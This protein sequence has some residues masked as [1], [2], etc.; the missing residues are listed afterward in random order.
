M[1]VGFAL[2]FVLLSF[3]ATSFSHGEIYFPNLLSAA[4]LAT[5]GIVLLNP[6][7]TIANV[8]F[9]LISPHG[10]PVSLARAQIPPGGQLAKVASE[11][12]SD[13][14]SEGWIGVTTDVEEM[15]AFWLTWNEGMT[16]L[17]GGQAAQIETV[18]T[19]QVIP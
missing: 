2:L 1:R 16:S 19:D 7:P 6:D 3:P 18:G 4:E 11:L 17:D 5:T 15:D 10:S 13:A 14:I 12:F 9:Y 8:T